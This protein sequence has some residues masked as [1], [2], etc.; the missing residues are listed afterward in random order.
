MKAN[1]KKLGNAFLS[2][3]K[4]YLF[5]VSNRIEKYLHTAYFIIL[6]SLNQLIVYLPHYFIFILMSLLAFKQSIEVPVLQQLSYSSDIMNRLPRIV[7]T[8]YILT[9]KNLHFMFYHALQAVIYSN[10]W[11]STLFSRS[12]LCSQRKKYC[13]GFSSPLW[14]T[15]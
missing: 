9:W 11:L 10:V 4:E 15:F 8:F 14:M 6:L 5:Q 1:Y 7:L 3:L 12:L 2:D 13:K